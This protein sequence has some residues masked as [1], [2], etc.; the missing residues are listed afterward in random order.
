MKEY[1]NE[2]NLNEFYD[3]CDDKTL[4]FSYDEINFI[5]K[6]I[7]L[8]IPLKYIHTCINYKDIDD[9][10]ISINYLMNGM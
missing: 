3:S 5:N 8:D 4:A 7:Y 2:I 10:R 1:Y 9:N 6:E